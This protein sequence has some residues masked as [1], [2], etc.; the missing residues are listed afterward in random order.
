MRFFRSIRRKSDEDGVAILMALGVLSLLMVLALSFAAASLQAQKKAQYSEN[1][2]KARIQ[3]ES[4]LQLVYALL[5]ANFANPNI[6]RNM[7]PAT[8]SSVTGRI[9]PTT[10]ST[11]WSGR[12]YWFSQG[13]DTYQ[14]KEAMHATLN[15]IDITPAYTNA[16]PAT[17]IGWI[18]VSDSD[19][20]LGRIAYVVI[21]E[22]GKLDPNGIINDSTA[23]GAES[24]TRKHLNTQDISL[25]AVLS[26]NTFSKKFQH[27]GVGDGELPSG[28]VW[29]SRYHIFAGNSSAT[30][31]TSEVFQE[32]FPYSYDIEAF[33]TSGT[34]KH[35]FQLDR[36][37]WASLTVTDIAK[38]A[39]DFW[40]GDYVNGSNNG[41]IEWLNNADT[42]IKNQVIA[43]LIDYCD[44][45]SKATTDS[46]TAPTYVGL[47]K[48]PYINDLLI[49][50]TA[51]GTNV[52]VGV[53]PELINMYSD[54]VGSG[55]ALTIVLKVNSSS[56]TEQTL[57]YSWSSMSDVTKQS[58]SRPS[59]TTQTINASDS[60]P[61]AAFT[62]KVESAAL[63]DG[64]GNLWDFAKMD[65][66]E[67][68]SVSSTALSMIL[69]EC[70]DPR[71]NLDETD[72]TWGSW[73]AVVSGSGKNSI[74]NPNP[75]P[76]GLIN[77]D[78]E[79]G[80]SDPWDVSTA[81][82]R[83]GPME[84]IWEL[85]AIHRGAKWET[86]NL[87]SHNDAAVAATGMGIY[88]AGDAN[89]MAQVK[90]GS[91]TVVQGKVNVNSNSQKVWKGLLAGISLGGTYASPTN[92]NNTIS[93]SE[94]ATLAGTLSSLAS[95]EIMF[96]NGSNPASETDVTK[97]GSPFT[98]RGGIANAAK[99]YNNTIYTSHGIGQTNDRLREEIIGKIANLTTV[100]PNYFTA[101][102]TSQVISDKPTGYKNGKQGTF[103]SA[104]DTIE[105]EQKILVTL[106]RDALTNVFKV[107]RYEYLDE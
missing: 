22:S 12:T 76:T 2:V 7:F 44:S 78:L 77:K 86:I 93:T 50:A 73:A 84:T 5:S 16:L 88:F 91:D 40:S 46:T 94:A 104:I 36:T 14:I 96:A 37:D 107:V 101:I 70:N 20:V 35:R 85:G 42:A 31:H 81:Y 72:W 56:F 57:T 45:D 3:A 66:T 43:N 9:G 32:I 41:G 89:I 92:T 69:T 59:R 82:I 71:A 83:N 61:H 95:G 23:E 54:D 64:S 18:H 49:D 28:R 102:I 105:A 30:S 11:V 53:Q 75:D 99:L 29:E 4:G 8:K 21:D 80:A 62:V 65:T 51:S 79:T 10:T 63:K 106:H 55:G 90:L 98:N 60:G 87:H 1:L 68:T 19:R 58:Y 100:R 27:S 97:G 17:T 24:D 13:T 33:N 25:L 6:D 67:A 39:A 103:E 52:V 34:D 74:C 38:D 26:N 47:E 48:V 15:G